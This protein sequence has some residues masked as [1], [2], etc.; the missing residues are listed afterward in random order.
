MCRTGRFDI[1]TCLS[2]FFIYNSK[3]IIMMS[4]QFSIDIFIYK[5]RQYLNW[6]Q[7]VVVTRT[8]AFPSLGM[9]NKEQEFILYF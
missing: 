4:I 8:Q 6:V 9:F 5:Y 3:V 7:M 2:S 1:M